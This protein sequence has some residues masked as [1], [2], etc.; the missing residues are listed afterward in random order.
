MLEVGGKVE[1]KLVGHQRY[2]ARAAA[3]TH[4]T[5]AVGAHLYPPRRART[6]SCA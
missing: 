4:Y 2:G 6:P 5:A 1:E 3:V